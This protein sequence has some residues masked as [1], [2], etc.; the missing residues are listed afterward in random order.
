[1]LTSEQIDALVSALPGCTNAHRRELL[2]RVLEEWGRT[3]L[4][5]HLERATPERFRAERRQMKRLAKCASK[6]ALAL[7]GLDPDCRFAIA[8]QLLGARPM[9]RRIGEATMKGSKQIAA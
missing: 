3:D 5:E 7:S 9:A 1:M 6:L 2:P 8:S 4:E